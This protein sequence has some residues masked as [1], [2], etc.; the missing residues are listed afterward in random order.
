M[1]IVSKYLGKILNISEYLWKG[2]ALADI[3]LR[4]FRGA[5]SIMITLR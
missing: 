4:Y 2:L 1:L 5:K 3:G